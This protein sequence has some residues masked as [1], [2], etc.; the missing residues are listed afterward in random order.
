[1]NTIRNGLIAA[2]LAFAAPLMAA[3]RVGD[4]A[5]LDQ[6]GY[7][8]HMS[9]YDNNAMIVLLVHATDD[10]AVAQALPTFA[11]LQSRFAEQGAQFFMLNP[12]GLNDRDAVQAELD[13]AGIAI[14]VLMDDTQLIAEALGLTHTAEVL[15]F[16]PA[17]FTVQ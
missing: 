17:E 2:C 12:M 14:P 11:Q 16:D 13:R 1:M 8:H 5:L 9:W 3:E 4:F 7:F 15:V 6:A 10:S